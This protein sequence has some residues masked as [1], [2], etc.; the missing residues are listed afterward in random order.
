MDINLRIARQ[1]RQLRDARGW[2]LDALAERSGVSRSNISLIERGQSSPTATV[3][4]KLSA[5]LGVTVATLFEE[6]EPAGPQPLS[7]VADQPQWQDP[8]SGYVRRNLS[9]G[10]GRLPLQLVAVAFPPGQ[11]V[12]FDTGA[13]EAPV[14][15]QVWLMAGRMDI[16]VGEQPWS[17][18]P[19]D[20]LAMTLDQPVVFHNPGREVAHYLVALAALPATPP[21]RRATLRGDRP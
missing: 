2:S 14:H 5:G 1:L 10:G 11:R 4:D 13:R 17:L 6:A 7:R 19:G 3:L 12:A 15:Q 8:A 9:P 20:C 18:Q 16:S 21:G